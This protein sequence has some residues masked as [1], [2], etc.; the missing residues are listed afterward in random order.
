MGTVIIGWRDE[1]AVHVGMTAWFKAE[2]LAKVPHGVV[3]HCNDA[4][5]CHRLP[6]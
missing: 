5:V 4:A 3:A 6:R 2:C 1:A